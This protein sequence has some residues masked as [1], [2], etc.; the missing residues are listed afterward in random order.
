MADSGRSPLEDVRSMEGLG[1]A[2]CAPDAPVDGLVFVLRQTV[3]ELIV[4]AFLCDKDMTLQ[5]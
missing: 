3:A 5:L 2:C 4:V 1:L